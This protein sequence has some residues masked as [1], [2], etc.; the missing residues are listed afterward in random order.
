MNLIQW[1]CTAF[2]NKALMDMTEADFG[3]RERS[4]K[5][6]KSCTTDTAVELRNLASLE[7][8]LGFF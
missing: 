6:M 7:R 5:G 4:R 8:S 1:I 2:F 3:P